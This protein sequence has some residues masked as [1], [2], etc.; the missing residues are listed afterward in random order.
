MGHARCPDSRTTY[1]SVIR[2]INVGG[3]CR[4]GGGA[5]R[6]CQ[7]LGSG[8]TCLEPRWEYSSSM[9]DHFDWDRLARYVSG[10]SGA[11]ERADIER[12][13]ASSETNRAM[14]ESVKRRWNVAGEKATWNVDVAWSRLA[15]RLKDV[16]SES[17]VVDLASRRP[18]TPNWL[19]PARYGLAAAAAVAL[20]AVGVRIA[21]DDSHDGA[22]T[23]A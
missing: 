1:Q 10:E 5:I 23:I 13:A 19:Q 11:T 15:P 9:T 14:L 8:N 21:A 7:V 3:R 17:S 18:A 4:V 20:I 22:G 6:G 16:V 2:P 12:W